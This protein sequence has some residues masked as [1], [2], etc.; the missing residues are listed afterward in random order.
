MTTN[1][2]VVHEIANAPA[3]SAAILTE[4]QKAWGFVP[5][6]H[7]VL[8]E[9]PIALEAYGTLWTLAERTSFTAVERN[10]AFLAIIYENACVYCMAGH[11]NLSKMAGVDAADIVAVREGR[12]LADNKLEAL[13]RFAALVTK[14][15]GAVSEVD[16]QAFKAAGYSN[17]SVLDLLVLAATKLI[18]NYTNHLAN[19]PLD[20]FMK[21]AEWQAPG[22]LAA[23]R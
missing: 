8:A 23:A 13:R 7:K 6:L 1:A 19:T 3:A 5:N 4:V 18:S 2:F 14:N 10:I 21:G 20:A 15:R 17:Q 9:S 11:T 12:A 16:V 22:H